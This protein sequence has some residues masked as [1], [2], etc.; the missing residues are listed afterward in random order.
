MKEEIMKTLIFM[1][2]VLVALGSLGASA[3]A[4]GMYFGAGIG[5]TFF[6]SDIENAADQIRNI[7]EN[8]TA[9]K[10]FAGFHGSKF[11]GVEGGYRS[12][13]KVSSTISDQVFESK[14][15]GWD[16]EALGRIQIIQIVDVF[17]KAGA[18]FWST[19]VTLLGET[20][21]DS[22]T[23][24]FW[25]LGAG[26]HLGPIGARLEW[27]SVTGGGPDN[28]SMVSLSATLGF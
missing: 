25:G 19:E 27:E 14:T 22:G 6:S 28:L 9:W 26:A 23:D 2:I 11:L 8:S 18:M 24:F 10:L 20:T 12:F 13:G 4:R 5:N 3:H 17:A 15:D 1:A 21:D 16:V 7:D